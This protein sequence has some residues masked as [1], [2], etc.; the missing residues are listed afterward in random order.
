MKFIILFATLLALAAPLLTDAAIF[1][2]WDR[3]GA[4]GGGNK[5]TCNVENTPCDFCDM[6]K[7]AANAAGMLRDLTFIVAVLMAALGAGMMLIS[8]GNENRFKTGKNFIVN[9][10]IGIVI[11]LMAWVIVNTI[12][13]LLSGASG[14][15]S[16]LEC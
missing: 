12:I 1:S 5:V 3:T 7:V 8:A 15:W 4:L 6:V 10:I 14:S 9:A 2:I 11:A 16:Q 13:W